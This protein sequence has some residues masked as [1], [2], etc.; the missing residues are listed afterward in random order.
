MGLDGPITIQRARFQCEKT[1][2]LVIPLDEALDLPSGQTTPSLAKRAL[3]LG[4]RM[5]F[6]DLEEELL[7]QHDVRITDTTLDTL[8]QRAGGV[9]EADRQARLDAL[10]ALPPGVARE[11]KVPLDR[12]VPKC[13]YV[14]CDGIT[15]RTCYLEDDPENPGKKRAVYHEMKCGAVFWQDEKGRWHKQVVCGRD[16]PQ[17]FGLCLWELAVRCGLLLCP[18]VIFISDGGSWCNTVAE[19][20]FKDATRILDWYHLS[21]YVWKA[22]RGLHPADQKQVGRW[23]HE[24]LDHL[25]DGGGKAMLAH[26]E[27]CRA[28]GGEP[29]AEAFDVLVNYLRPRLAI[30]D[31]PSYRKKDYVIGSGMMESSC[32]QIV[33]ERLKGTGMQ[34][35]EEGALAMAALVC[36]RLNGT[37][38]A[39][40]ATRP[41]HRAA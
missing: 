24:C 14:S 21:E 20:Y 2:Q 10:A 26:L 23:V 32:K 25:H 17:H 13:L 38:E 30:T 15:Y 19:S 27:R 12:A 34:W 28:D 39:F 3:R 6:A 33:G 41:L 18:E 11:Q 9:A 40:W 31:Y 16:D 36:E 4:T 5:S 8:M 7:A 1:G 37:L 29:K 22:G 35:S